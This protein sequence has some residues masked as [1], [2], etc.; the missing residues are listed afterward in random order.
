MCIKNIP[1]EI[2][3]IWEQ[4]IQRHCREFK[5]AVS[6]SSEGKMLFKLIHGLFSSNSEEII[7]YW[8]P[9]IHPAQK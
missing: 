9:A 1:T 4:S 2:L 6:V 3:Y 8:V 5:S 7:K